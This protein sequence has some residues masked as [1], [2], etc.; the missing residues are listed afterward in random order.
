MQS[1]FHH[2]KTVPFYKKTYKAFACDSVL[3]GGDETD[4]KFLKFMSI[5]DPISAERQHKLA[6][7][8]LQRMNDEFG[9]M[10]VCNSNHVQDRIMN[11]A[12]AANIP[13]FMLKTKQECFGVPWDWQDFHIVDGV[14]YEHGHRYGGMKPHEIA[15]EKNFRS[16]VMGHHPILAVKYI[17]RGGKLY[18]GACGGAMVVHHNDARMGFGM[19]Y[20][21]R[22]ATEMPLGC[23][24]IID[25]QVVI[26]VPFLG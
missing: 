24:V 10:K 7:G 2:P 6:K 3:C 8:F 26:P 9:P 5:N 12:A 11:A 20:A 18:F 19:K 15:I 4:N 14:R 25:G 13:E 22:Y 16:V 17:M 1:P 23:L 21:K